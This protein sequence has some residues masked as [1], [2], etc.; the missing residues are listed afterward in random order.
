VTV[1]GLEML[2]PSWLTPARTP[3]EATRLSRTTEDVAAVSRDLYRL[4][5]TPWWWVDRLSWT[6][7]QWQEW[8][9]RQGHE[10]WTL[11]VAGADGTGQRAGYFELVPGPAGDV[12]LAYFGLVPGFEGR[13]LGGHLLTAAL[14]RAWELPGTSRVWV[15]TCDLDGPAAMPNYLARGL[16]VFTTWTEHRMVPGTAG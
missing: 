6:D 12:L 7:Q 15:H 1:T 13:G 11:T 2:D 8:V 14:R 4:V 3:S 10:L 9:D 16:R 5:G